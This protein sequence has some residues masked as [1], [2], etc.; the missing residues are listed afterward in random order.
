[1]IICRF[2]KN[3]LEVLLYINLQTFEFILETD[4]KNCAKKKY[5]DIMNWKEKRMRI[6]IKRKY[7]SNN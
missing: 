1:M 5:N 4:L 2:N 7:C 6:Q 3:S